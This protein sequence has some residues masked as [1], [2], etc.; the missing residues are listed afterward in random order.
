[1]GGIM[2]AK[3]RE[4]KRTTPL[5]FSLFYFILYIKRICKTQ[6]MH[7]TPGSLIVIIN[8]NHIFEILFTV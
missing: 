4:D 6:S 2:E 1:M 5:C 7:L 8:M 3:L